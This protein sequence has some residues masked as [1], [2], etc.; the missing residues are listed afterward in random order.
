MFDAIFHNRNNS[1]GNN[2]GNHNEQDMIGII[3]ARKSTDKGDENTSLGSQ[4]RYA[5][6]FAEQQGIYV[7]DDYIFQENFT[8]TKLNRPELNHVMRLLRD[9]KANTLIAYAPDRLT[10]DP[11]DGATLRNEFKRIGVRLF[12]VTRGEVEYN[13]IY[14]AFNYMQDAAS[15]DWRNNLIDRTSKGIKKLQQDKVWIGQQMKY[16]YTLVGAAKKGTAR[17]EV[18]ENEAAVIRAIFDLFVMKRKTALEIAN[19]FNARGIPTRS[20]SKRGFTH[21]SGN[22]LPANIYAI[23]KDEA[24]IGVWYQNRWLAGGREKPK[25]EWIEVQVTPIISRA[26][27]DKAQELLADGRSR[28]AK[29]GTNEYLISRR[30]F[31]ASCGYKMVGKPGGDNRYTY[32]Y[33]RCPTKDS[34]YN[35]RACDNKLFHVNQVDCTV[36]QWVSELVQNPRAIIAAYR[37]T[38][39]EIDNDLRDTAELVAAYERSLGKYHDQLSDM[40]D[41]YKERLITKDIFRE[42]KVLLDQQIADT[43]Q[44]LRDAE[45]QL[46]QHRITEGDLQRIETITTAM[47]KR[48]QRGDS[49]TFAEKQ[50]LLD[51][52]NIT[53]KLGIENGQRVVL[54]Y[55]AIYET[56][57]TVKDCAESSSN[58]PSHHFPR[59]NSKC[60]LIFTIPLAR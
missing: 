22:W 5:L 30:V 27:F 2:N 15:Q 54:V 10:R 50:Q 41:L 37:E 23:L 46:N 18:V 8:G 58:L 52:L 43:Q 28:N 14:E 40:A 32:K 24:Y 48:I 9:N 49:I 13:G 51:D 29:T 19:D 34:K 25:D 59:K 31:C 6:N 36:W 57:L 12:F 20:E 1:A 45:Q 47:R 17:V 4:V 16:G 42:K 44:R 60:V 33:Y 38:Q 56:V 21:T 3:Y 53:F 26:V 11:Y 7:P 39:K 35:A 55:W